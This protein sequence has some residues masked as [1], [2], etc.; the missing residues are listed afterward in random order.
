M[1]AL[2]TVTGVDEYAKEDEH[3][4]DEGNEDEY[5]YDDEVKHLMNMNMRR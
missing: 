4:Y 3:E 2:D 1:F 5:Q